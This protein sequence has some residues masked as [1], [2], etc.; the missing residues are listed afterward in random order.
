[1][2]SK[3]KLLKVTFPDGKVFCY[4]NA[5]DTM[6]CVLR[7][8][9]SDKFP[10]IK[11]ELCH[12]PMLSKE[13]YPQYKEYMKPICDG[14]Y[15]NSQSDTAQKYIQ[16]RSIDEQ[17]SLGLIIELGLDFE[18]EANPNK[19]FKSRKK[20]KLLVEFPDGEQ[21]AHH[22]AVN[23]YIQ[24]IKKLGVDYIMKKGF[25]WSNMDLISITQVLSTQIQLAKNRWIMVPNTTKQKAKLLNV[26]STSLHLGLKITIM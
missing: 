17:L 12:L 7:E 1:M 13:I 2:R 9:G 24:V 22:N 4:N 14:W 23:T 21:I 25:E 8:I 6:I 26:I 16:L 15:L 20:D 3:R 10:I 11:M 19:P 5:T 18:T